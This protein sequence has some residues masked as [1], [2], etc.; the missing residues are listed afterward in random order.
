MMT[1]PDNRDQ[2]QQLLMQYL[3]GDMS[4]PERAGFEQLLEGNAILRAML[5]AEHRF[6]SSLPRGLQPLIDADRLQGNRWLLHQNLQREQHSAFSLQQWLRG[7]A[8]RP[9]AVV[10]QGAA[11][12]ATFALG[13]LIASPQSNELGASSAVADAAFTPMDFVQNDDFEIFEFKVNSYDL[14]SGEIDLSFSLASE[15]R[16]SGNVADVG[17][18]QLMA[19]ALQNDIDPAARMD[20]INVL[21][22]VS[23]GSDVYEALIYVLRND[24]NPGVRYQAVQSLVALAHEE[25]VREALRYALSEDVNP[26]VRLEAFQALANYP[27]S[28]TLAVFREQMENDSNEFIRAQARNIVEGTGDATIDL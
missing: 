21:H 5:E 18:H 8:E 13:L 12:A 4:E 7:M 17:I 10:F 1:T 2:L 14:T 16:V 26:G 27:D 25:Q 3:Y 11:M 20:T 19:V 24:L 15:T 22:P 6:D 9:L 28:K 23:N